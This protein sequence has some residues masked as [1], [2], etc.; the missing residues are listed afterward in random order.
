MKLEHDHN[1]T[2][3]IPLCIFMGPKKAAGKDKDKKGDKKAADPVAAAPPATKPPDASA[4]FE[5]G[6]MF[7]KCA[8]FSVSKMHHL[9]P[10]LFLDMI[11]RR[12]E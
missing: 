4:D 7:N 1:I 8:Y 3:F 11:S 5:A 12:P 10:P 2:Y 9:T 6:V